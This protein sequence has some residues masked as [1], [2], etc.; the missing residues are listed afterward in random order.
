MTKQTMMKSDVDSGGT[1]GTK[2]NKIVS[3]TRH[4]D[5]IRR[6]EKKGGVIMIFATSVASFFF[7]SN[8]NTSTFSPPLYMLYIPNLYK[9]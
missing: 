4:L 1:F 9:I 3:K 2:A 6:K 8:L 5:S 7:S